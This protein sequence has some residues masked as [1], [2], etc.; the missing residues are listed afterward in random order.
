MPHITAGDGVKLYY[1]ETGQGA[2]ILFVHEFMGEYRSW[3][4]QLRYFS[5]RYRCIAYNARGYPPSD[6]PENIAAYDFEY[7][8]AGILAMLD[9]LQI[10][11]A[12]IV[13]L[14]M[15]AFA[16]F[17]FGMKWPERALSLTLAGVGS[18]SMPEARAKFR[19][20]S[21]A[22]AAK[23]LAEGWEKSAAIRGNS[24]T[25]VQ[26]QN[27][28]PRAFAEFLE[29][30]KQHSAKGSAL[31]LQGYQAL[32]PSL[33]DFKEQM[34][35]CVVPTLIISGDEDEPCLDASLM[36]KRHMPAAG[37]AFM[38]Q[39]GHACNLEE[40]EVFNQLC[41]RFFHQVES[42]QYR[43]RDPRAAPGRAL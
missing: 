6:V 23:L 2:P 41:E 8:R 15:G 42:G 21:E 20:E 22:A 32:R 38:P 26:L 13:G 43:M 19:Q 24:P 29:L 16:T 33:G 7:Q 34:A 31:T 39:T 27:K 36:L 40:P 28:N 35:K 9:G 14:S 10:A 1:E 37:L 25:R 4:A 17:Y 18:G 12:H 5:R 30:V 11:K 3:E